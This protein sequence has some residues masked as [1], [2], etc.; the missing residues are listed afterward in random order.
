ML[1]D[2]LPGFHLIDEAASQDGFVNHRV[3]LSVTEPLGELFDL[4]KSV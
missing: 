1:H 4:A 2:P 3:K